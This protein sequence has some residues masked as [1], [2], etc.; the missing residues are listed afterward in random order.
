MKLNK[1]ETEDL[2]YLMDKVVKGESMYAL[3]ISKARYLLGR[4]KEITS[5]V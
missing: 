4:I 1:T 5:L 2:I 3:E